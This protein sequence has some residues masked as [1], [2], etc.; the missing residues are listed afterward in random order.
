VAASRCPVALLARLVAA[1]ALSSLVIAPAASAA[2]ELDSTFDGDG[3]VLT[4]F[5]GYSDQAFGMAIQADGRIVAV[6]P[7][8]DGVRDDVAND[9][10]FGVAIQADGKIVAAGLTDDGQ[11]HEHFALARYNADGSLDTGFDGD[12]KLVTD[13]GAGGEAAIGGVAIQ[14]DG[15]IVAAGRTAVSGGASPHDFALARYNTDGSLDT[16]FDGDGK[17]VTDF[18]ASN[19]FAM[20]VAIQ[21]DGRIVAVGPSS[22]GV[23]D[24]FALARYNADG[25]LDTSFDGDGRVLTD[26]GGVG[27]VVSGVA[28]DKADGLAIQSDGKIVAAGV[29]D[30]GQSHQDFALARY[31]MDGSLDTGFDGDGRLVT[32]FGGG[33][34]ASAGVAIQADGTIVAAGHGSTTSDPANFELARYNTDGSLDTGF[35]GDGKLVTDFGGSDVALDMAIQADRKIAA[36]GSTSAGPT[37]LNFALARYNAEA[38]TTPPTITITTPPD[39]TTY[40]LDETVLADY[41]CAD[42]AGG[43]GLAS[44]VGNV[45][46][47]AAIDTASVGAKT[48]TVNAADNAGNPSALTH[49][50]SVV[51]AFSGFFQPVDNLPTWN[52]VKAGAGVPVKFSLNGD[53]GLGIFPTAYPKSQTITCD[54]TGAVDG[55]EETASAGAS[56]LSYDSTTDRYTY[57]WK[58]L[59]GWAGTCRQF[60]VKL[61][62]GTFHRANFKLR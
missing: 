28:N 26:F 51:Y 27:D 37:P 50:Y 31:N 4:D 41:S 18:R 5:G 29:A 49:D 7:S 53:Q 24:D 42:E 55:I 60:V 36:A 32:D 22:D 8:S 39:G 44:C 30:D 14:A 16:S 9:K 33:D 17:A 3:R 15:R 21:A 58:T 56:G 45:A 11:G 54:Y 35:D 20:G 12:G 61:T 6:G 23:R 47:G 34:G 10:P 48:F 57:V 46:T 2:G 52:S 13:F 40:V 59:K 25:S 43:S 19:D 62:D 38:D 1:T